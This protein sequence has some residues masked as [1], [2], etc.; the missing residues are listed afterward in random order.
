MDIAQLTLPHES[1]G[2]IS[3]FQ[4]KMK[5]LADLHRRPVDWTVGDD[6]L[7]STKN[8]KLDRPSRKLSDKWYGPV[9][10]L[11]KLGESWK[12]Q[13]PDSLRSIYPVFHSHSLRKYLPNPLPGQVREPPAPIKILLE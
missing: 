2:Q 9:K 1:L 12:L 11:E 5:R 8:W 3:P 7:I 4:A 6:V 10:V 13:L